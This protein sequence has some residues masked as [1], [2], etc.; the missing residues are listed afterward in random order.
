[1]VPQ[2]N[3]QETLNMP[4]SQTSPTGHEFRLDPLT[5]E[6]VLIVGDRQDRPN[7]PITDCPFC[8][9]GLEAP[10]DYDTYA[11]S[12]RWPALVAG[13]PTNYDSTAA[14]GLSNAP[15]VGA[16]EVVLYTPEHSG[17]LATIGV[18][19][20]RRVV[21]LWAERTEALL[22]TP[23]I[24]SVLIF[25]NRGSEVGATIPHAHGQIY[26]FGFVTPLQKIEAQVIAKHGCS[27]CTAEAEPTDA[28]RQRL[29][30]AAEGW[31]ASVP[32]AAGYP[33][34]ILL[35]P[36]EHI[37]S[38][39]LL[40]DGSRHG[41]ALALNNIV[42]RYDLLFDAPMPYMMWIHQET[43]PAAASPGAHLHLH[44]APVLRSA[45]TQRF[46]AAAEIGSRILSN[47]ILPE[48]AAQHLRDALANE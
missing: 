24:S 32:Y 11:F 3:S 9:G 13:E 42:K 6:W 23:E 1:M 41:L 22:N 40:S 15:A 43:S 19:G 30:H 39:N 7:L 34:E 27:I 44:F 47:P 36:S 25:E 45:N 17:S 12:N 21:D 48:T 20:C 16:A 37:G 4:H 10:D 2:V 5:R 28:D 26:A 38:L 46:V 8:P 14:A 33:Y 31:S 29:V 18:D 35:T